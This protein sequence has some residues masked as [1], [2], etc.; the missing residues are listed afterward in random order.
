MKPLYWVLIV[1]VA[2][3]VISLL[4]NANKNKQIAAQA[5]TASALANQYGTLNPNGSSQVAQIIGS[6]FPYFHDATQAGLIGGG[7][8][9]KDTTTK[10]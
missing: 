5:A 9:P 4:Y 1:V 8:K 10:V 3:I 2:L 7:D 6:L